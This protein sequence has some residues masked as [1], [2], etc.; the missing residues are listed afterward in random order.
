MAKARARTVGRGDRVETENST[1]L[2]EGFR[3]RRWGPWSS[4]MY[5]VCKYIYTD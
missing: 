2:G 5:Y 3:M 1:V 4:I